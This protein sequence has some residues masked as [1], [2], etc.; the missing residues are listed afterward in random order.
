MSLVRSVMMPD[1][2]VRGTHNITQITHIVGSQTRLDV[3]SIQAGLTEYAQSIV[4]PYDSGLDEGE[5]YEALAALPE[6]AEYVDPN[7][8]AVEELLPILTDE[9][10]EQVTN[11]Y[12][13]W[14]AG[15]A[16]K[17]GERVQHGGKL[18]RCVQAHTSQV[19]WEPPAV[20]ALWVRTAKEGE[21]P[22]W[23]Q[24]TGAHDAYQKGDR[25]THNGKTWVSTY[26]GAN[27]WE[28]GIAGTEAMWSEVTDA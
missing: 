13:T 18:Y 15:V 10:A 1:G 8:E 23:V 6:F 22:E 27:V 7:R 20:P 25:V 14:E 24:P 26:D 16:Y 19:G 17:V 5:A 9:Q 28:P 12:P 21:I 11:L 3:L 4:L 2:T